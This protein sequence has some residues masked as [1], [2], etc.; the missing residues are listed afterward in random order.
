[1]GFES[2][3]VRWKPSLSTAIEIDSYLRSLPEI[4]IDVDAIRVGDSRYYLWNDGRHVV[5]IEWGSGSS[6]ASLSARFMLC[7]PESIT[8][9]YTEF[10]IQVQRRF[11]GRLEICDTVPSDRSR[12]FGP[13][14]SNEFRDA[15][16]ESIAVRR[17]EWIRDFGPRTLAANSRDVYREIILPKCEPVF[18]NRDLHTLTTDPDS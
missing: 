9:A 3:Q 13:G 15:L 16:R 5:E 2:F 10:L 8:D 7:N 18:A 11:G 4:T 17:A 14:E 1:M 6:P 12:E